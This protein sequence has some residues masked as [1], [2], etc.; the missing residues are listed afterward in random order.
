[1]KA[2]FLAI[3]TA[4]IA[5]NAFAFIPPPPPART[6]FKAIK[7]TSA[8]NGTVETA[9]ISLGRTGSSE[10]LQY[11]AAD[12]GFIGAFDAVHLLL[13]AKEALEKAPVVVRPGFFKFTFPGS[14]RL[15]QTHT[16]TIL[17]KDPKVDDYYEGNWTT[18]DTATGVENWTLVSCGLYF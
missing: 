8:R 11:F 14:E 3:A 6:D 15:P 2:L 18:V 9:W 4:L 13:P 12:I 7:C 16:I 17:Q 5:S 1:M 10:G